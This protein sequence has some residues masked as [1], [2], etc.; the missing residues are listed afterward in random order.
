MGILCVLQIIA[1]VSDP[2]INNPTT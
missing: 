1:A 2:A